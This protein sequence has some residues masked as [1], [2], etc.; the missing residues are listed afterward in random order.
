MRKRKMD[1]YK[2]WVKKLSEFLK[3]YRWLLD[4]YVIVSICM[5]CTNILIINIRWKFQE[6]F[7]E[8]HWSKLPPSWQDSLR[9]ANPVQISR[10]L[11]STPFNRY[12]YDIV[13]NLYIVTNH[14]MCDVYSFRKGDISLD[15]V[16]PLSLL[17]FVATAHTL[18]VTREPSLEVEQQQLDREEIQQR[19]GASKMKELCEGK[20]KMKEDGIEKLQHVFRRHVKPKKQHEIISLGRV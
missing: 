2:S 12:Q 3:Q 14:V 17:A 1:S 20:K 15:R 7:T 4:A 6:F 18:S 10:L 16:Y 19:D 8:D 13:L 9:N 5:H 11:L